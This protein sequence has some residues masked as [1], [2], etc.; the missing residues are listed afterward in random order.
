MIKVIL[1]QKDEFMKV[2]QIFI[3]FLTCYNVVAQTAQV[4]IK[5]LVT[6]ERDSVYFG[7]HPMA[8]IGIDSALGE[9]DL[10][11]IPLKNLDFRIIQRDAENFHCLFPFGQRIENGMIIYDS[12]FYT[13]SFDSKVNF[14]PKDSTNRYFEILMNYQNNVHIT[15]DFGQKLKYFLDKIILY[16]RECPN[17]NPII[18]T[19]DDPIVAESQEIIFNTIRSGY[20]LIWIFKDTFNLP[21]LVNNINNNYQI[22]IYPNPIT[23]QL[24]LQVEGTFDQ[25]DI[26]DINGKIIFSDQ[27][28]KFYNYYQINT[29]EWPSGYYFARFID[30]INSKFI[31]EKIV[32]L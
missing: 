22:N 8:T 5:D 13:P 14:R 1:A 21:T 27:N 12:L 9:H 2:I 10:S 7:Y 16:V 20:H 18:S 24:N 6:G 23:S 4:T 15:V 26:I 19:S 32:K 17:S 31:V 29:I 11:N 25:L 3:L 28:I 30:Q